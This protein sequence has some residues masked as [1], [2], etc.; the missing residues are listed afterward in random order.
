[1]FL[2][3]QIF[4]RLS[5]SLLAWVVCTPLWAADPSEVPLSDSA[6]TPAPA[7]NAPMPVLR[8]VPMPPDSSLASAT[9]AASRAVSSP[10]DPLPSPASTASA[11]NT[12]SPATV[13]PDAPAQATPSQNVTINLINL[14]VKRNLIK[15]SDAD[16]LI[17]QAEQEA[18]SARE[19]AVVAQGRAASTQAQNSAPDAEQTAATPGAPSPAVPAD[20]D[21]DTVRV[22]YVPD[23]VRNQIRDEVKADV[24]KQAKDENWGAQDNTPEWVHRFHVNGDIRVR[25]EGD[26]F[27]DDNA[28]GQFVNFNAINTGTPFNINGSPLLPPT[29]NNDQER[30]RIRLRARIGA[31]I[32][33]GEG[34]TAGMRVGTGSDNQPVS[35]NQT[36]G[37]VN[38][39]TQD[40]GGDFSKYQIWLDRAFIQYEWGGKPEE[41]FT[42]AAGRFDNPFF[43]T[44]MIWADDLAFDGFVAKAK[45]QV[46][47]GVTPFV[48]AGAFPVFNTDL[49][50]GTNS[51][52]A[53]QGYKS[54]DKWLY[55][56]QAGTNWKID[57]D[58]N[59]KGAVAYYDFD[60]IQGKV[61]DPIDQDV[62]S[63]VGSGYQGST[64]DSRPL[65][66]Q[67]GNTYI[68][69]RD[70]QPGTL[71]PD[72]SPDYQYYGLAT[73][74]REV[75]LTGQ[76][77][78]SRFDPFHMA[79]IGEFVDNVAFDRN[80]ILNNG[81]AVA[82]G[83]QNN[84]N[85]T[86]YAGGN[87]GYNVRLSMGK[88]S[89]EKLWDWNVNLTYR[90]VESDA[91]VDGFTDAD[92]GGPLVG[93]NLKGYI[94]GGNLALSKRI[95]TSLRWMSADAIAGPTYKNDLIQ[96]DLNAKF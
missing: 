92:F 48:T 10:P 86:S 43:G 8:P 56:A 26:F 36:L 11:E 40:Q 28:T 66:A 50:F 63:S 33:L 85:G 4:H 65:F 76:L 81:P 6:A 82:P 74:F 42:F 38:S 62:F 45:Y 34:F 41:D 91:T 88:P 60:N 67:H 57:K 7:L 83:P 79:L 89:L 35:E 13:S 96:F 52:E 44:S 69:L 20:G 12:P 73:P 30:D 94:I 32:D 78:F 16:D 72:T 17:K 27:P 14:M 1:M 93:T 31:D 21:D 29:Y 46:T 47:D 51:T 75:A 9:P 80:A 24:M 49:N 3:N 87:L 59:F 5:A 95:W 68:A 53:G 58:F 37:G 2:K 18:L 25:Y 55:A 15:K 23:V 54:E 64:D 90:Y 77:D 71:P 19:Q 84:N 70:V 61:S 22:A 39:S